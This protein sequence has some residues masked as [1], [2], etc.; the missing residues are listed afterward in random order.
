MDYVEKK[1]YRFY[2]YTIIFRCSC[3]DNNI[4]R[5]RTTRR[6]F[7]KTRYGKKLNLKELNKQFYKEVD[8]YK[9]SNIVCLDEISVHVQMKPQYSRCELGK[10]C[11]QKTTNNNVFKKF[12]LLVAINSKGVIRWILYKNGGITAERLI[13]FIEM[14]IK[15]KIKN[16]LII[17]DN[18]G[19]HRN[20][21]IQKLI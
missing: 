18:A 14:F 11:V 1:I 4:T 5:K 6:H 19:A 13:D 3:R 8:K 2:N 9:L 20:K 16:W 15:N 21:L 17:M 10:C 12:T 7:P